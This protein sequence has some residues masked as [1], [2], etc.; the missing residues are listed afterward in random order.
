M[1]KKQT[2]PQDELDKVNE[3]LS[4]SEQFIENNQKNIFLALGIV[5]LCAAAWISLKHFYFEPRETKAYAEMFKGEFLLETDS[6]SVA[7]NGNGADYIGFA[8]IVEN[9]SHTDA[10]NLAAAYAGICEY[11]LGNYESAVNYF[12][13]FKADDKFVSPNVLGMIGNCYANMDRMAD[14]VASFEKAA[15]KADNQLLSPYYLQKAATIAE[16]QGD[17]NKALSL[18]RQI[19]KDYAASTVARDID[20]Y[21]E[22]AQS[23]I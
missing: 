3:V 1:A 20:K 19:K 9:Y 11:N 18:Y 21:I 6:F 10:A 14:A 15:K 16:A 22:R 4:S 8:D 2:T 12:K 5:I 7:L 17:Y 13:K 23:K